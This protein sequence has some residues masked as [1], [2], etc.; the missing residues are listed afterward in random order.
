V[1]GAA[2]VATKWRFQF[3]AKYDYRFLLDVIIGLSQLFSPKQLSLFRDHRQVFLLSD[4]HDYRDDRDY[5][6]YKIGHDNPWNFDETRFAKYF[7]KQK[8]SFCLFCCFQRAA[9]GTEGHT[10]NR[11]PYRGQRA[12]EETVGRREDRGP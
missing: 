5:G 3:F 9:E 10:G 8:G 1:H 2:R 6:L 11:G 12:V 7:V 4:N